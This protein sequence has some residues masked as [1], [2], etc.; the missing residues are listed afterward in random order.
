[1]SGQGI[2]Y[3]YLYISII[4]S[5]LMYIILFYMLDLGMVFDR[6]CFSLSLFEA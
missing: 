5:L 6:G 1:M 3:V 4:R 2:F